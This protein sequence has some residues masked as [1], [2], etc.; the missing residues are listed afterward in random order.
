MS[1]TALGAIVCALDVVLFTAAGGGPLAVA[2]TPD[3]KNK[4][5]KHAVGATK[6]KARTG[7]KGKGDKGAGLK[8]MQAETPK[9]RVDD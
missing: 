5:S 2:A 4:S 6:L 7:L 9:N 3:S 8:E 1:Q